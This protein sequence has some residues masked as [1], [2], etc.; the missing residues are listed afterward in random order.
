[1]GNCT[2]STAQKKLSRGDFK[3]SLAQLIEENRVKKFILMFE[4][5][6]DIVETNK[7][8][9]VMKV[10]ESVISVQGIELS[11][12]A[13]AIRLGRLEIVRYLMEEARASLT[14]VCEAL[15]IVR[16]TPLDVVCENG[17]LQLLTYL[18]PKL[19][20]IKPTS[21]SEP[22]EKADESLFA[23]TRQTQSQTYEQ[24]RLLTSTYTAV[25]RACE[26]GHFSVVK[27]IYQ[28]YNGK[29]VPPVQCDLNHIDETTGEN[30]A[31]L[32]AK[33]GNLQL[34]NFL[35]YEVEADFFILSKRRE[36]AIQL[37]VVG[38]KKTPKNTYLPAI[39]FLCEDVGLDVAYEYEE[40]LLL[41]EDQQIVAYLERELTKRGINTNKILLERKYTTK[42]NS[43]TENVIP[44][45]PQ[46]KSLLKELREEL[47][48]DL[49]SIQMVSTSQLDT[50]LE[51][52]MFM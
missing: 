12:L 16:K 52:S 21:A 45:L 29:C 32:A 48:S 47:N 31:L 18:L 50:P 37:A 22:D 19:D 2:C 38:S 14:K 23:V 1:M 42:Y 49:S 5:Y 10:D 13:Y 43:P 6:V 33:S 3:G 25:Q 30:C 9:P 11:A 20:N 40:T 44:I 24:L 34:L 35:Y 46:E 39:K 27:Y 26:K 36:S 15:M 17:H 41:A 4:T 28:Y 51:W 7:V 8:K